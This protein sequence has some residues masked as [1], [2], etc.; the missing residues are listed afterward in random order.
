MIEIKSK[1]EIELMR[2]AGLRLGRVFDRLQPL[3]IPGISTFE[4][5][6]KV[7]KFLK[8]EGC[9]PSF[10]GYEGF[11]AAICASVNE[12]LIHGIPSKSKILKDGDI[13]SIDMGNIYQGYQGDAARTYAVGNVSAEAQKLIETAEKCFY[14]A[15]EVAKPG[16]RLSDLSH[17]IEEVARQGGYGLTEDFGGHGIG[18]EMHEDPMI[19]N[20]GR[21]GR[22]P[23]LRAGMCLAIEPM[24]NLGSKEVRIMPDGWGVKSSDGKLTAHYENTILITEAGAEVLTVDENVR[25]H[26]GDKHVQR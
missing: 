10:K 23:I 1:R 17:A 2:Q 18:R 12:I 19:L 13:I 20:V 4:L 26:I 16:N 8:E 22:G 3:I 15:L 21:P 25:K 5:D 14:A 24:L 6:A 11:P 9:V 7:E